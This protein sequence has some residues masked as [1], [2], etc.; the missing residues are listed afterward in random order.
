MHPSPTEARSLRR[1]GALATQ[2]GLALVSAFALLASCASAPP[3]SADDRAEIEAAYAD[4]YTAWR[5]QDPVLAAKH[6]SDDAEFVNAFG[7]RCVGRQQIQ[8]LLEEVFALDFVMAGESE[9]VRKDVQFLRPDVALVASEI[10]RVGQ[11]TAEDE[12]LGDRKTTHLRVFEKRDGRWLLV[13]HLISDARKTER[14][15]H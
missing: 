15:E 5:I 4:W 9:T 13:S 10:R 7:M 6:Y 11:R 8:E 1:A 14:P 2:V 3:A 12:A